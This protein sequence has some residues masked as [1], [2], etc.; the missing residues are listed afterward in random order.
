[1]KTW[2][3]ISPIWKKILVMLAIL[4]VAFLASMLL[5]GCNAEKAAARKDEK[6]INYVNASAKRQ[7]P[8]VNAWKTA[9][10]QDTAVKLI[11][12]EPKLITVYNEK[13]VKDTTGRQRLID[14]VKQA[15]EKEIDCGKAAQDAYDLGWD[16]CEK[17]YLANPIKAKCPPDTTK[18]YTL[19][20][21]IRR[22]Q[23]TSNAK[24]KIIS[25][26]Q[27]QND[28]N[29]ETIQQEKKDN[30]KKDWYLVGALVLLGL[31]AFFNIKGLITK[32][33]LP[34]ILKGK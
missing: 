1:M 33:S 4:M 2:S 28:T 30:A 20:S 24:D 19:L 31:S 25:N 21:E 18:Q 12:S 3:D 10:P 34:S 7:I 8:V 17:Q 14:S 22:W 32:I 27:G 9:N 16:E 5:S 11:I 23:D 6:Y 26:L 13:L 29:K 15:H